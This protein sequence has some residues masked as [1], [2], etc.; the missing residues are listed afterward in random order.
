MSPAETRPPSKQDVWDDSSD[1]SMLSCVSSTGTL[2]QMSFNTGRILLTIY[3]F[4]LMVIYI[5]GGFVKV[6]G[7]GKCHV[8]PRSCLLKPE[9]QDLFEKFISINY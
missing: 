7:R 1:E 3:T 6:L 4:I 9:G 2:L 5:L 8:K